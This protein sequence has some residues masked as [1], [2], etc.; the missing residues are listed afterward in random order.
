M[1]QTNFLIGRGELL[2]GP[3][4]GPRRGGSKAEVYSF[5]E[6]RQILEPEIESTATELDALPNDACPHDFAVAKLTLHPGYVAKSY[7]PVAFLRAIGL[8]SV[9][10]R[11]VTLTPK[12]W[13]R[14]GEP[15]PSVTTELFVAGKRRVFR[16]L[17]EWLDDF[18]PNSDEALD[19]AHIE[20]F[21][22]FPAEERLHTYGGADERYFE[23]GLHLLPD[24]NPE[25]I[26]QGFTEYAKALGIEIYAD[27]S[28]RAGNLWFAP[29]V[30]DR[31]AMPALAKFSFVRVIRPVPNLRGIRPAMRG[32]A[33]SVSCRLPTEQ[34]MSSTPKVAIL[35]GGLP[36]NHPIGPWLRTYTKLDPTAD[37][38]P[39][40]LGH[41]LGV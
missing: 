32:S 41:G 9:G 22:T 17:T 19:F 5:F 20:K 35:D 13:L 23:I 11:G 6:A 4:T 27:L 29:V 8:E 39:D 36:E 37:D 30:G 31:A 18:A 3:I 40:L 24:E 33:I 38:E 25:F 10:S 28:F 7:F 2:T 21:S 1:S 34:P 26:R 16:Q 12:K 15:M 14:Q